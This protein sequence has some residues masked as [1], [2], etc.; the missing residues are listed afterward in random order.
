MKVSFLV[1]AGAAEAYL[2]NNRNF[3]AEQAEAEAKV[4]LKLLDSAFQYAD[5]V[6]STRMQKIMEDHQKK[7]TLDQ[8]WSKVKSKD[9]KDVKLVQAHVVNTQ[10][11]KTKELTE[12]MIDKARSKLNSELVE[13]YKK[14]DEVMARCSNSWKMNKAAREAAEKDQL[15]FQLA[16]QEAADM[17]ADG[18]RKKTGYQQEHAPQEEGLAAEEE[19]W[20]VIEPE[21]DAELTVIKD[22]MAVNMFILSITGDMV[23]NPPP[24][25]ALVQNGKKSRAT[26]KTVPKKSLVQS[27]VEACTAPDGTKTY[28]FT[29]PQVQAK[30]DKLQEKTKRDLDK[31]FKEAFE[32]SKFMS[33]MQRGSYSSRSFLES[34]VKRQALRGLKQPEG[35]LM[36]GMNM[37]EMME[38]GEDGGEPNIAE[39]MLEGPPTPPPTPAVEDDPFGK[40]R[41]CLPGDPAAYGRLHD[42]MSQMFGLAADTLVD[43]K[44]AFDEQLAEHQETVTAFKD[45][46][47]M[48]TNLIADSDAAIAESERVQAELVTGLAETT[49]RLADIEKLKTEMMA[50]CEEE[51]DE[52]M[53]E[54]VCGVKAVRDAIQMK[55]ADGLEALQDC[56]VQSGFIESPCEKNGVPIECSV[57]QPAEG[58][59]RELRRGI[60]TENNEKGAAC[61]TTSITVPCGKNPCPIDCV[62]DSSEGSMVWSECSKKCNL[63]GPGERT[64][65]RRIETWPK[66]GGAKCP[67]LQFSEA[68][69]SHPCNVDCV[70]GTKDPV[71]GEPKV[72]EWS[73]W[74]PCS[75]ACFS[76]SGAGKQEQRKVVLEEAI[77][78]GECPGK[79]SV[80]RRETKEC[81]TE[82]A[83][84][85]DEV[86]QAKMQLVI[87]VDSSGSVGEMNFKKMKAFISDLT[88]RFEADAFGQD[89]VTVAVV[90]YG[91]GFI[92]NEDY[93][94][95]IIRPA[96]I[97][98]DWTTD[99]EALATAI[100]PVEHARGFTNLAQGLVKAKEMFDYPKG[101]RGATLN[102]NFRK[103]LVLTDGTVSFKR[104]A[105][106]A[107]EMLDNSGIR[108]NAVIFSDSALGRHNDWGLLVTRPVDQSLLKVDSFD[109]LNSE[110]TRSQT[111][112]SII[113][114]FC[115]VAESPSN[116]LAEESKRAYALM[117]ENYD[118][119]IWQGDATT[120]YEN[121]ACKNGAQLMVYRGRRRPPCVFSGSDDEI[122]DQCAEA[123]RSMGGNMFSVFLEGRYRGVCY[124]KDDG[125]VEDTCTPGEVDEFG[126]FPDPNW[127]GEESL[128]GLEESPGASIYELDPDGPTTFLQIDSS[129]MHLSEDL[130]T[131]KITARALFPKKKAL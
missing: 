54:E 60:Y 49:E 76:E 77:G 128:G 50:E 84:V 65:I 104:E 32:E 9:Q 7:M 118:C 47:A 80:E 67:P 2:L 102:A 124:Y 42:K 12:E 5:S 18:E 31:A 48:F 55:S 43:K 82:I 61:P 100:E 8:A 37:D 83:C 3:L 116:R 122:K 29:D 10:G 71:T 101:F 30:L 85:G 75:R 63:G 106:D 25:P 21:L 112:T 23:L 70:L 130:K 87:L 66:H 26:K 110:K 59:M 24:P 69:N 98:Q 120:D 27:G 19:R 125:E 46:M 129:F 52:I 28:R 34:G 114:A 45:A 92:E 88:A 74:S 79:W 89:G 11:A 91:N 51:I 33:F 57:E 68:C 113:S 17:A 111:V 53:K 93:Q 117:Y 121:F 62:V 36:E 1:F 35:E 90:Q 107:F 40:R 109:A 131:E 6:H 58:G 16:Q 115:P 13:A 126:G 73:E 39:Q 14:L 78:T 15:N 20:G 22:D 127:E 41:A 103:V 105:E 97:I 81:N 4:H 56:V 86:C 96:E 72:G 94:N 108:V 119:Q 38:D 44:R 64:A 99:Y 123:T 95:P